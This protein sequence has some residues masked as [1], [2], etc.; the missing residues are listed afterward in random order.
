MAYKVTG[1]EP[2]I[3]VLECNL[4]EKQNKTDLITEKKKELQDKFPQATI[5]LAQNNNAV[6]YIGFNIDAYKTQNYRD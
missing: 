3:L 1:Y 6:S 5:Q 2:E 4:A